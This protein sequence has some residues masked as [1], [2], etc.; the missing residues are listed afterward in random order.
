MNN[1]GLRETLVPFLS[2]FA[3]A[4]TLVCCALPALMV[5][6]G[7]GAALAGLVTDFPALVWLSAHKI[8]VFAAAALMIVFAGAMMWQARRLPC[9]VDPV[10]ARA[11]TRLRIFSWWVWGFSVLCFATGAFFAFIAPAFMVK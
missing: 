9:P 5:S 8:L 2:L 4:G 1:F 3:S 6:L 10:K 7:M 11:C